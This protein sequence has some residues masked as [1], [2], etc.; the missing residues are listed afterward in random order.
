[1]GARWRV[2]KTYLLGSVEADAGGGARDHGS[3]VREAGKRQVR[4]DMARAEA[5]EDRVHRHSQQ[6]DDPRAP[7]QSRHRRGH[8]L[9]ASAPPLHRIPAALQAPNASTPNHPHHSLVPGPINARG[10]HL[11]KF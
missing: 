6:A 4:W 7:R 1:M 5:L 10:S 2:E 8:D 3:E 11:S 9:I